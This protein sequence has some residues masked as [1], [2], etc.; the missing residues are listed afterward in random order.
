MGLLC[1]FETFILPGLVALPLFIKYGDKELQIKEIYIFL[2][3]FAVFSYQTLNSIVYKITGRWIYQYVERYL[4]PEPKENGV[5]DGINQLLV[6]R[7]QQQQQQQ[8]QQQLNVN[9]PLQEIPHEIHQSDYDTD[10]ER[11]DY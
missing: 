11:V 9:L 3:I 2:W 6:D 1:L 7:E 5:L 10:S 4:F 8:Q